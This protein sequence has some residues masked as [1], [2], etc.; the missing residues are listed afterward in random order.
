MTTDI[1]NFVRE[2]VGRSVLIVDDDP[3]T[4]LFVVRAFKKHHI[5]VR[6]VTHLRD[7]FELLNQDPERQKI[8]LVIVDLQFIGQELPAA[9]VDSRRKLGRNA[10]ANNTGQ[11]LG[12]WLWQQKKTQ[13]QDKAAWPRYVYASISPSFWQAAET[14]DKQEFNDGTDVN[15]AAYR[16]DFV[17]DKLAPDAEEFWN[18]L[19]RS[20]KAWKI[21]EASM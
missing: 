17:L 16:R 14:P 2:L 11:A 3:E 4:M 20:W 7:A 13:P 21:L 10:T 18:A 15:E 19:E 5:S 6:I 1:P 12:Y 9:L 8:G